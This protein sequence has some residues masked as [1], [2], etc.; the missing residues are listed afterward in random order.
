MYDE[1]LQPG[2]VATPNLWVMNPNKVVSWDQ[3]KVTSSG[4]NRVWNLE[5]K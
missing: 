2:I 1:A 4:I 5:V 3:G